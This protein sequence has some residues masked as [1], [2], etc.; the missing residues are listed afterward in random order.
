MIEGFDERNN[1]LKVSFRQNLNY[2][3]IWLKTYF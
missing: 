1:I 2:K 3:I